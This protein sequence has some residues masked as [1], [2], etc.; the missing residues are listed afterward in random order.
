MSQD[1]GARYGAGPGRSRLG[2]S[3]PGNAILRQREKFG[4]I[5]AHCGGW[6]T[7][8]IRRR[9]EEKELDIT[10]QHTGGARFQVEARQHR[11]VI[12]Q[13]TEDGATDHGMTPAELLLAA[14]GSSI[15]QIVGQYLSLRNLPADGMYVRVEADRDSKPL[16]LTNIRVKIVAPKLTERQLRTI[17]KS[18]PAGIVQN[19]LGR[20]NAVRVIAVS[21]EGKADQ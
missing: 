21:A 9:G 19:T 2:G 15:G 10:L 17:E 7:T 14:L 12:D 6:P 18:F 8:C 4:C 13:P 20:E 11:I 1:A 3:E 16:R 5:A